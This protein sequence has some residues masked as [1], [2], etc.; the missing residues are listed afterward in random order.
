MEDKHVDDKGAVVELRLGGVVVN[1]TG[2]LHPLRDVSTA[3]D[4]THSCQ[5]CTI[6]HHTN[7]Y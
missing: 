2:A 4:T 5:N 7:T 6:L 1:P 3:T